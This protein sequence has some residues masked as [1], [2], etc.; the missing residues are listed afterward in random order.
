MHALAAFLATQFCRFDW[1]AAFRPAHGVCVV[2][3]QLAASVS[4]SSEEAVIVSDAGGATLEQPL[5][6]AALVG[7]LVQVM[8]GR[9]GVRP[10]VAEALADLLNSGDLLN[11]S[12]TQP[13][14][15]I[16]AAAQA[17]VALQ[18]HELEAVASVRSTFLSCLRRM[19]RLGAFLL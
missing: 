10:A 7:V 18:T 1:M 14:T 19:P 16:A 6:R 5:A 9:A 8:H 13:A 11:L 15:S 4:S 3:L 17:K 2:H 12:A